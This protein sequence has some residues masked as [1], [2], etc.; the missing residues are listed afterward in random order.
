MRGRAR[1]VVALMMVVSN[2]TSASGDVGVSESPQV[3]TAIADGLSSFYARH[4]V[5]AQ[6]DFDRA[7]ALAPANAFA[8]SFADAAAAQVPEALPRRQKAAGV[9]VAA[10]PDDPVAALHRGYAMLFALVGDRDGSQARGDLERAARGLRDPASAHDGLGVLAYRRRAVAVAKHEFQAALAID[11]DDPLAREYL[12]EIEQ[13]ELAD[14]QRALGAFAA[15]PDLL[16]AY[17]DGFFHLGS[18]LVDLHQPALA[19]R[20]LERA[21]ALD[22][23]GVG[24]AGQF[25]YSLLARIALDEGA[26]DRAHELLE[27]AIAVGADAPYAKTLEAD[28]E[29]RRQ[30]PPNDRRRSPLP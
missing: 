2:V 13:T 24:Q 5:E 19:E 6:A 16:P 4:F 27:R 18:T 7:L 15:L 22:P 21:V 28:L 23:H 17:A 9:E 12:G 11:P 8:L 30:A 1:A 29:R 10:H 3:A 25:G 26:Y 14:P 20:Y